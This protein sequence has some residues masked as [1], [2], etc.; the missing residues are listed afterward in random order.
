MVI[1]PITVKGNMRTRLCLL[2]SV[3]SNGR[4]ISSGM[5]G[6]KLSNRGIID[7]ISCNG[8]IPSRYSEM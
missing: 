6:G 8:M 3:K 1:G 2:N 4:F 5:M 7:M